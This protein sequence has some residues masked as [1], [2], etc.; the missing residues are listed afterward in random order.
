MRLRW[1]PRSPSKGPQARG[2]IPSLRT[3]GSGTCRDTCP[4]APTRAH[5]CGV[6]GVSARRCRCSAPQAPAW[7]PPEPQLR[8]CR[9]S[10]GSPSP[11][12]ASSLHPCPQDPRHTRPAQLCSPTPRPPDSHASAAESFPLPPRPRGAR[13]QPG[14]LISSP[15]LRAPRGASAPGIAAVPAPGGG[16]DWGRQSKDRS[17][18]APRPCS[19]NPLGAPPTFG[20]VGERRHLVSRV[21]PA[22]AGPGGGLGTAVG[23]AAP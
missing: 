13:S 15:A 9:A 14:P 21:G 22:K 19:P 5:R 11:G 7:S 1:F 12:A 23:A 10:P 16:R 2:W 8:I 17:R 6:P 4:G 3:R 20:S 18:R